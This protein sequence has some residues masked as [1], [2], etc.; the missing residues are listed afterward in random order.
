VDLA[1][2]VTWAE[3]EASALL[4]PLG[5]RWRHVRAVAQCA[6]KVSTILDEEDR[7]Y[8]IT[9]SGTRRAYGELVFTN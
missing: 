4:L 8:L 9:T 3:K 2:L 6:R 5:D 7:P 1:E